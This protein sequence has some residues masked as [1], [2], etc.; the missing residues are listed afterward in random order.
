MPWF[1]GKYNF[2]NQDNK[3]QNNK[4]SFQVFNFELSYDLQYLA[5]FGKIIRSKYYAQRGTLGQKR[6]YFRIKLFKIKIQ[7]IIIESSLQCNDFYYT[8]YH[9]SGDCWDSYLIIDLQKKK[10]YIFK[11][12]EGQKFFIQKMDTINSIYLYGK[13]R[14]CSIKRNLYQIRFQSHVIFQIIFINACLDQH[15]VIRIYQFIL[16]I[17]KLLNK[18]K[19][20][21]ILTHNKSF[22]KTTLQLKKRMP[23]EQI[24]CLI[25]KQWQIIKKNKI[26]IWKFW[27]CLTLNLQTQI[28]ENQINHFQIT[29]FDFSRGTSKEIS[30]LIKSKYNNSHQISEQSV[31]LNQMLHNKIKS[32]TQNNQINKYL[33]LISGNPFY[34]IFTNRRQLEDFYANIYKKIFCC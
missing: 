8:N 34:F 28:I 31:K 20:K 16:K 17:V 24:Q 26:S 4:Y 23:K 5:I 13:M 18:E 19:N 10:E 9:I 27:L 1:C 21:L 3:Q 15:R 33:N 25:T 22:F 32:N 29:L 14:K 2:S 11:N 6:I 30:Y 7:A 12:L